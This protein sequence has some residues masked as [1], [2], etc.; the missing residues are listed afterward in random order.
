MACMCGDLYCGSCGPAQGNSRCSVC[1]V[2]RADGGCADPK[3]CRAKANDMDR[4]MYLE[5]ARLEVDG[6]A[7]NGSKPPEWAVKALDQ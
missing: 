6:A 7:Y 4:E 2:W 5:A 3:A 1:G